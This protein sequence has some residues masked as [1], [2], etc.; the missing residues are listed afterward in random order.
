MSWTRIET[1][2]AFRAA[3]AGRAFA[4]DGVAFLIHEDGRITGAVDG[5]PLNGRWWWEGAFLCRTA[6]ID[7]ED[8]GTEREL[9]ERDGDRVRYTHDEGRGDAQIATALNSNHCLKSVL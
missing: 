6:R 5:R 3:F 7:V 2:A 9:I 1:E 8:L 4:A